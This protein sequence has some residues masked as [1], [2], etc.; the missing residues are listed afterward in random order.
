MLEVE[1]LP[2]MVLA[3]NKGSP[4]TGEHNSNARKKVSAGQERGEMSVILPY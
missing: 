2:E 3:L 1:R 4:P